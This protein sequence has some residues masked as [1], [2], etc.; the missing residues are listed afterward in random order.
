MYSNRVLQSVLRILT[1]II[2][3]GTA[4]VTDQIQHG[5]V[6]NYQ[7]SS[8]DFTTPPPA[9]SHCPGRPRGWF[10]A[11]SI[12][13]LCKSFF[14]GVFVWARMALTAKNGGFRPTRQSPRA[15]RL[16]LW[17]GSRAG[18]GHQ[19][20]SRSTYRSAQRKYRATTCARARKVL[21]WHRSWP[22]HSVGIHLFN[23]YLWIM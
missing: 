14:D 18:V 17:F 9:P 22:M 15:S 4:D 12:L 1:Y 10:S 16:R 23:M 5:T 11:L 2:Y 13:L 21:G 8:S 3:D 19:T 7:I 6:Q 20:T